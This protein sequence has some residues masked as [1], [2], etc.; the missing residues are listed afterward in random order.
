MANV[1]KIGFPILRLPILAIFEVLSPMNPWEIINFSILSLRCT[2]IVKLF[3][4]TGCK[5]E[6]QLSIEPEAHITITEKRKFWWE[7][8]FTSEKNEDNL[9]KYDADSETFMKYSSNILESL[10]NLFKHIDDLMSFENIGYLLFDMSH[11]QLQNDLI[12]QEIKD[13]N[14]PIKCFEI[15]SKEDVGNEVI[16]M[17]NH[18]K[19]IEHLVLSAPFSEDFELICPP[20]LSYLYISDSK[21][22]N[23][24]KLL[25]FNSSQI[26]LRDSAS[27]LTDLDLCAFFK[28]WMASESQLNLERF[29]IINTATRETFATVSQNIPHEE[30]DDS[31]VRKVYK[32][33]NWKLKA[34]NF[35]LYSFGTWQVFLDWFDIKRNDGT[36]AT[37]YLVQNIRCPD[38]LTL[39]MV[40][41]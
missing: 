2:R 26:A 5:F 1:S 20:N 23:L 25:E 12:I 40:V 19:G 31:V 33:F 17:L 36:W 13:F 8:E 14:K 11:F 24:E 41:G 38:W 32:L 18:V 16:D 21:W 22:I 7:F 39:G 29:E 6:L 35:V 9:I 28:S 15:Y 37:I 34:I 4:R 27:E 3:F 30:F 10:F